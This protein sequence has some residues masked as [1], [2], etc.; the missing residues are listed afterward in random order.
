MESLNQPQK[1]LEIEPLMDLNYEAP[2]KEVIK[3]GCVERTIYAQTSDS[4]SNTG[5][6]FNNIAPASLTTILDRN[7]RVQYQLVTS[8]TFTVANATLGTYPI[9][10]AI[11]DGAVRAFPAGAAAYVNGT[12]AI[13]PVTVVGGINQGGGGVNGYGYTMSL[14]SFPL[15]SAMSSIELKLNGAN[16]SITSNDV[17][18]LQPYLMENDELMYFECPVERDNSALYKANSAENNRNPFD[19]HRQYTS[20]PSRGSYNCRLVS[21]TLNAANTIVTRIYVWDVVEPLIISPLVWG[22]YV[23]D[24]EGFANLMN[25]TIQLKIQDLYRML[26]VASGFPAGNA[27]IVTPSLSPLGGF[28]Q[29]VAQLLLNY[30]TQDPLFAAK[31]SNQ[32]HYDWDL[33][34]VDANSNAIPA[35][36]SKDTAI[37][38]TAFFGNALRLSTIPDKIYVYIQPSKRNFN[39]TLASSQI[40]NTYLRITQL[41]VLFGNTAN[42]LGSFT[43]YDLWKM[44]VKNGLK[45]D[46][47]EWRYSNGSIIIID[48]A[49]DLGLKSDEAAGE[50]KYN[51]IKIDGY[52]DTTPLV[53]AQQTTAVYYD[54]MTMIVTSGEAIVAPNTVRYETGG[55]DAAEVLALSTMQD[56][57]VGS[58][59]RKHL[60][61]RGGNMFHKVGRFLHK[62]VKYLAEHPNEV[63]TGLEIAHKGMHH[64]GLGG[65]VIGGSTVGGSTVGGKLVK[66][67][68]HRRVL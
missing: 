3:K 11:V 22:K 26:S 67:R 7:F 39:S 4:L 52:Y 23:N 30:S 38:K 64:L 47:N 56:S 63:K 68:R 55:V 12:P 19:P 43:E 53:Y 17:I 58:A 18:S 25:I 34:Q 15:N 13:D 60:S 50:N 31:Q 59:L 36:L 16:T 6:N 28:G 51:Q 49:S 33:I 41:N 32:L 65:S 54:V 37:A 46:W 14:R 10:N 20:G 61:P 21:E 40:T 44:S 66:E 48:T 35:Q 8:V 62:S 9:P 27:V 57:T 42:I 45:M 24:V 5:I 2:Q 29:T 1:V